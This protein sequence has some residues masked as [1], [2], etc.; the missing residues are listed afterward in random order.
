MPLLLLLQH[1]A[2]AAPSALD[3]SDSQGH[4]PLM[5][6]A[7]Q[8][9][10][11]SVDL[12]LAHGANV[13][14]KDA[15]GLTPMHWAVVKG[16]RLCIRK[17]A[18]TGSDLWAKEEGG[19]TPR[20]MAVELK[21][22]A[23]YRKAL[24]DVGLYEDG[25]RKSRVA[26]ERSARIA[27]V[28]LPFFFLG[29]M[30]TTLGALPWFVG[31][32]FVAA[33]FFGMHHVI[34]RVLLDPLEVDSLQRSTYFLGIVAGSVAWV[35]WEWARKVVHGERHECRLSAA[36]LPHCVLDLAHALTTSPSA[37]PGHAL[38]NLL[39]AIAFL[40]C[41][42]NLF[43]AATL[44]AGFAPLPQTEAERRDV[45]L[46]LVDEGKLNGTTYCIT[47]LTRRPMRSKHCRLCK[48]C[49][50]RHD[51][52]CPWVASC[53]G[54]NNH[55]QFI[56]FVGSLVIG[57]LLFIYLVYHSQQTTTLSSLASLYGLLCSSP[58]PLFFSSPR[59][60]RLQDR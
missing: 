1:D 23:A 52:H 48:R 38:A 56:V 55:R 33:E 35:G 58:G 41:S 4:T 60:G 19:K 22:E 44:E 12:L 20:E 5:W 15:T 51:H 26:G 59:H 27:I 21:S 57:I 46:Q 7:Y 2:F 32:P 37:T 16:N 49:V 30:F 11:L 40:S 24:A 39:F 53:V 28:L 47:C 34:T 54:M 9:D 6:A 25:R 14:A 8:G 43:R 3:I 50:A 13:H 31:M 36:L 18:G 45:I 17:L 42:W 29:L 10:A